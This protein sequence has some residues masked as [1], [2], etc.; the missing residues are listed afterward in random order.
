MDGEDV[1]AIKSAMEALSKASHKLAEIMYAEAAKAHGGAP[2]AEAAGAGP[3]YVH[4]K[5]EAESGPVD[6]DFTVVDEDES[7][8]PSRN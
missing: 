5:A 6:A 8:G 1:E 7:G 2:G 4:P 3:E